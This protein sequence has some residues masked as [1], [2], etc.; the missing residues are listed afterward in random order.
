VRRGQEKR[1]EIGSEEGWR[2][3]GGKTKVRGRFT[4]RDRVNCR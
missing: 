4:V 2:N 1:E 3:K